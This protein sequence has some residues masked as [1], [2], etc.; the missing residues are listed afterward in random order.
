MA[1]LA[2]S[3]GKDTLDAGCKAPWIE[4]LANETLGACI[5]RLR[6]ILHAAHR[7]EHKDGKVI[8]LRALTQ[9]AQQTDAGA[10]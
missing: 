5:N 1:R 4:R 6:F 9:L 8:E 3:L 7:C 10:T 2:G